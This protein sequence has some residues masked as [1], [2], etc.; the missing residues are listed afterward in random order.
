MKVT[1]ISSFNPNRT[2]I[3]TQSTTLGSLLDELSK[4]YKPADVDGFYDTESGE[5]YPDC[6]IILNGKSYRTTP[7]GLDT[8]LKEGDKLEIIQLFMLIGG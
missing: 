3:E 2:E 1:V 7:D 8:K 4:K 6:D 5:V